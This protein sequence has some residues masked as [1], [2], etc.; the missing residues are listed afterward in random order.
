MGY[1]LR[2]TRAVDWTSNRGLE[3]STEEWMAIVE[4]DPDLAP[5]P[6]HGPYAVRFGES[7]DRGPDA[8]GHSSGRIRIIRLDMVPDPVEIAFGR[9]R[10][11]DPY[12][13]RRR[14]RRSS[15]AKTVS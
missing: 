14:L 1:D 2:I 13:A 5:D 12:Q 9:P 6:A 3:I 10:P 4:A 11:D 8:V 7:R 15:S